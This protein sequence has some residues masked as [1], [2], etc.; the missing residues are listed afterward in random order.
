M[1]DACGHTHLVR[2]VGRTLAGILGWGL[3]G[4]VVALG[5]WGTG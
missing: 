4:T 2:A 5:L 3:I 1:T